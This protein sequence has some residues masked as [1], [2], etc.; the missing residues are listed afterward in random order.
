MTLLRKSTLAIKREVT[1]GVDPVVA[2]VDVIEVMGAPSFIDAFDAKERNVI[3]NTM[4]MLESVRGAESVSGDI[5]V[6]AKGSGTAGT[7]NDADALWEAGVGIKNASTA[8]TTTTGSTTT[9]IVLTPGGGAGFAVGDAILIAGEKTWI[10]AKATDTLTVSPALTSA[11]GTGQAVGAGVHYKLANGVAK[12]LWMSFWRGDITREQYAG[13]VIESLSMNMATGEILSASFKYQGKSAVAP[14]AQAYGLGAVTFDLTAPL[15]GLNMTLTLGGSTIALS[16][17]A[18]DIA[19]SLYR[20]LDL[21]SSGTKEIK[22]TGRR[23]TGSF[24]LY[25]DSEAIETTFRNDTKAELRVTAGSTA[26]NIFAMRIPKLR[27]MA[28]PKS[29]QNGIYQYDVTW[30]AVATNGEDELTS[31]SYL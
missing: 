24:S 18:F 13:N 3:R 14:V 20:R 26:G 4:S 7:A 27:Y 5:N 25:Y 23:I 31:I 11:P 12:S 30:E 19:H 2:A 15:T 8:S 21:T 29:E 28:V 16:S 10:T 17:L 1:Y 6:E 22:N 9:S